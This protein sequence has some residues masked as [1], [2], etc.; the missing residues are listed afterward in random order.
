MRPRSGREKLARYFL[1]PTTGLTL[2]RL[3]SH[4]RASVRLHHDEQRLPRGNALDGD[5]QVA[6]LGHVELLGVRA[7]VVDNVGHVQPACLLL[8]ALVLTASRHAARHA[9]VGRRQAPRLH[10]GRRALL[11]HLGHYKTLAPRVH[12]GLPLGGRR[13]RVD[14]RAL[15][16]AT[17][18]GVRG[19]PRTAEG[20]KGD[21]PLPWTREQP[22]SS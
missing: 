2:C 9:A 7:E 13:R 19:A 8:R 18:R 12:D 5:A 20:A 14:A 22:P 17:T 21:A 10:L 4:V 1:E 11:G 15:V 16:T 6:A 3:Q